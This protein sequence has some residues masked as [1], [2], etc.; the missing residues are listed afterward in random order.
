MTHAIVD[1]RGT[2]KLADDNTFCTVDN[3]GARVCH[4]RQISHEYLMFVHL[5]F[6]FIVQSNLY[7]KWCRVSGI[8]FLTLF[9]G[10][11]DIILT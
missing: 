11:L 4:Q 8:A 10:V 5:I 3:E 7:L 9:D 2:H 6:I 1:T